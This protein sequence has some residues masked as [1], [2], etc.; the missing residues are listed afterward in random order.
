MMMLAVDSS[1]LE[2]LAALTERCAAIL[3]PELI[4]VYAA[5]SIALD[6]YQPGRSD[7]DVAVVC[8]APLARPQKEAIVQALRHESLACPARGLELV[9]YRTAAAAAGGRDPGFEVELNTGARMDFR[10]TYAGQDRRPEDGTFW[11]AIDRSILAE[12]GRAVSGPPAQEIFRSVSEPALVDLLIA[13][14]RWHL[15]SSP[16]ADQPDAAAE[17]SEDADAGPSWTDDAVLNACRAWQRVSTGQWSSKVTAGE[18]V[19]T[20]QPDI[21]AGGTTRRD[22]GHGLDRAVVRQA[23]QAR[24]GAAPPGVSQARGFQRQVLM[25]LERMA[26]SRR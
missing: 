6:A 21:A 22:D 8:A 16:D 25:L 13:S 26:A 1:V 18:Q 4:G 10:A 12:R 14:L 9:V 20:D 15:G 5:G 3:G 23:L 11:Y 19:L 24:A 2:Y 7:I 17:Q